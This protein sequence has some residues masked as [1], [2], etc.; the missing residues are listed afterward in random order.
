M[1]IQCKPVFPPAAASV[2]GGAAITDGQAF[3]MNG[4]GF[5]TNVSASDQA[6]FGGVNGPIEGAA[7]GT[8]ISSGVT[9]PSGWTL[10][11]GDPTFVSSAR[12]Y[13]G[14]KSIL[15]RYGYATA[16][17]GSFNSSL[18]QYAM[19]F[20]FG[21]SIKSLYTNVAYYFTVPVDSGGQVKLQRP[22][23]PN[24]DGFTDTDYP[25][26]LT[27]NFPDVNGAN[28]SAFQLQSLAPG[29]TG[30]SLLPNLLPNGPFLS[31]NA[32]VRLELF[33]NFGTASGSD[34]TIAYRS[35]RL[36]DGTVLSS[37]TTGARTIWGGT[38]PEFSRWVIQGY[39]GNDAQQDGSQ[40]NI[41]RDS[42]AVANKSA[43]TFPK[44]VLLGDASTYAACTKTTLV[45]QK[46]TSWSDTAI[47]ITVNK[48]VHS[49]LTGKYLYAMSAIDT[50]I[51]SSGVA[52]A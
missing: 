47:G 1:S 9:L 40:L 3:T 41:D 30:G 37:G 13:N 42:Y 49:N 36:S 10:P 18:F 12:A 51:N 39:M 28:E 17:G 16:T 32:W 19:L 20:N 48:G 45:I 21:A 46:F 26:I 7:T 43:S 34:G 29:N 52:L 8:V 44:S 38:D 11:G 33:F 50:A 5:G 35:T 6:F 31:L 22:V 15:H 27:N 4:S 24:G 2:G 14:T 25:N 23:G